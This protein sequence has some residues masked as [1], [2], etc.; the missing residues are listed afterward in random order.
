[1]I[2]SSRLPACVLACAALPAFALATEKAAP[3]AKAPYPT[4]PG[5]LAGMW[6]SPY[7]PD[8]LRQPGDP[9]PPVEVG[10]APL[11]EPW[12]S[13]I[14]AQRKAAAD[15]LAAGKPQVNNGV[16]CIPGGFPGMMG[17]VFPLEVLE[18]PQQINITNEAYNQ[19]RRIYMNEKQVAVDDAEPVF[20][21]HSVGRWEKGV[22]VV[23]TIG[24]KDQVRMSGVPHSPN[25]RVDERMRRTGP[26]TM[27]D[28]ITI[29]DP[30]YL[31]GPWTFTYHYKKMTGYKLGEFICENNRDYD[32]KTDSQK[33]DLSH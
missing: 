26:E 9:A 33:L 30:E 21:G 8:Q 25:M 32:P 3:K 5:S 4:G 1:M 10:P 31:T 27:E 12:K 15:A 7:P 22:L 20:F 19:T 2:R 14:A 28:Q 6:Q 11:K 29:T 24:M 16:R 17:P 13:E 18:T 23:N